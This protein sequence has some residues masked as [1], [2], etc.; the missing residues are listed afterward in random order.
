MDIRMLAAF[1]EV[2]DA[3]S[4]ST[5]AANLGYS[6]PAVSRQLAALERLVDGQLYYRVHGGVALTPE[7][8]ALLPV[9]RAILALSGTIVGRSARPTDRAAEFKGTRPDVRGASR[10]HPA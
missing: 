8:R 1:S 5:A 10:A 6:Q 4:I 7:G 3:R 9:V 2:A